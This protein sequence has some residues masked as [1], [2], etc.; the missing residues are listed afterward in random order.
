MCEVVPWSWFAGDSPIRPRRAQAACRH[1][2]VHQFQVH[3]VMTPG[4]VQEFCVHDR[5]PASPNDRQ[6]VGMTMLKFRCAPTLWSAAACRRFR[7]RDTL[8]SKYRG[9]GI[10]RRVNPKLRQALAL[11]GLCRRSCRCVARPGVAKLCFRVVVGFGD[12]RGV[13]KVAGGAVEDGD[14]DAAPEQCDGRF[15]QARKVEQTLPDD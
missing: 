6:D 7:F 10:V 12:A 1:E 14:E 11:H 9:T 5:R 2:M 3:N 13:V 15:G 8:K 4:E